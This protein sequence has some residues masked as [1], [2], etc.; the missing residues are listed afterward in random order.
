MA[1]ECAET[2][3]NRQALV[4]AIDDIV[5]NKNEIKMITP[6]DEPSNPNIEVH[7]HDGSILR[8]LDDN[9]SAATIVQKFNEPSVL[10]A[11]V[12][13][14]VINKTIVKMITPVSIE[15]ATA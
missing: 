15:T 10:M 13:D 5:I 14:G 12:G 4:T 3:N 11:A 2:L 9:Y 6:A 7:L 1:E 8:L